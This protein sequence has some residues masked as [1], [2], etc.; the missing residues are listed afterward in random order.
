MNVLRSMKQAPTADEVTPAGQDQPFLE[1]PHDQVPPGGAQSIFVDEYF[2]LEELKI[3]GEFLRILPL[4][5][6]GYC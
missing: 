2:P 4:C 1:A 6:L 5:F 3:L